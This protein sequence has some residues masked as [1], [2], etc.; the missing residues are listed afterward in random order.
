MAEY[1]GFAPSRG[2][3][4]ELQFINVGMQALTSVLSVGFIPFERCITLVTLSTCFPCDQMF[5]VHIRL[6]VN[7][8]LNLGDTSPFL[9]NPQQILGIY[10]SCSL[11]IGTP[12]PLVETCKF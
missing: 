11:S 8:L 4:L 9:G 10:S 2:Q 12:Y 6:N 5:W 7:H 3:E 1:L